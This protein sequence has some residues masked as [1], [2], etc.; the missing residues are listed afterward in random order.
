MY[1]IEEDYSKILLSRKRRQFY[2]FISVFTLVCVILAFCTP[3]WLQSWPRIHTEFRRLGLWEFCMNGFVTR[4]DIK[5][6]SFFG[7][8]WLFAPYYDPIRDLL[9][10]GNTRDLKLKTIK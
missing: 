6:R 4:R 2:V 9:T 1:K 8:W 7:C 10:P 5:M 3:Y